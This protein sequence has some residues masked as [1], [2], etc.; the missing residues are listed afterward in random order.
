MAAHEFKDH[1]GWYVRITW[2]SGHVEDVDVS[3]EAEAQDWIKKKS[4]AWLAGRKQK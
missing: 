2:L 3:S 1:S 4:A